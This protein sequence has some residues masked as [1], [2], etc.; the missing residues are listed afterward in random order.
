M[1]A[2]KVTFEKHTSN[3][4]LR[5]TERTWVAPNGH[6]VKVLTDSMINSKCSYATRNAAYAYV[7]YV[8]ECGKTRK[9]SGAPKKSELAKHDSWFTQEHIEST[10]N[11]MLETWGK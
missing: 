3:G 8:C 6:S 10:L 5:E 7:T 11:S 9:V 1:N 4:T 2:V